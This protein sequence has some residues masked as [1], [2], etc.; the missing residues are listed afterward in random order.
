MPFLLQPKISCHQ[1]PSLRLSSRSFLCVWSLN[2]AVAIAV[3]DYR[4]GVTGGPADDEWLSTAAGGKGEKSH[5]RCFHPWSMLS[6][7]PCG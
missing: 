3:G 7:D 4:A 6:N 5:G 2:A 1:H